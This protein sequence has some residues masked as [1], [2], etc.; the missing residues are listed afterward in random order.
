MLELR[1]IS[2][3]RFVALPQALDKAQWPPNTLVMRIAPDEIL[4]IPD[5]GPIQVGDPHAIYASESG[6]VGGWLSAG[7]ANALLSQH[8]EWQVPSKR[9]AFAQ[10]AIAGIPAK[11]WLDSDQVLF[12]IPAPYRREF[13]ERIR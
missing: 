4:A 6:F 10:G 11:V 9:P 12:V 3:A 1:P 5:P 13:E 2:S 8:C 7:D